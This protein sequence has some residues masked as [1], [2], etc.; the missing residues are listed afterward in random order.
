MPAAPTAPFT[1]AALDTFAAGGDRL[2]RAIAGLAPPDFKA[3]PIP[4]TWSIQQIVV[5]M[6]DSDL[7][8]CDR[9]KRLAA[10]DRPLLIGYD[11]NAFARILPYDSLDPAECVRAF[12]LNRSIT[13]Q[14]LRPL[15]DE[16]FVRWG[17][18]NERG[19]V[20]LG[21]M[22]VGYC[23]HLEHHLAHLLR[24]R[25]LLGKPIKL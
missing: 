1:R 7:V 5:H 10:M 18:H 22:I 14:M 15:S 12:A 8:G 3:F 16:A 23:D 11:E 19:K 24:K 9:L 25:E 6:M 17:I 20:S 13:A 2:T 21:D 4:G